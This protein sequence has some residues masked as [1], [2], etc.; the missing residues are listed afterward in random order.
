MY[1]FESQLT[2][3][4]LGG[5]AELTVAL[6]QQV[7]AP[8]LY[9]EGFRNWDDEIM[10]LPVWV[11]DHVKPG[12]SLTC[13]DGTKVTVGVDAIDTDTRGGVV[14]YGF[15]KSDLNKESAHD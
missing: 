1:E 8:R 6:L 4:K 7:S 9:Q 3:I 2:Q 5:K 10:L 12:E 11:V 13:I 14:A 15:C